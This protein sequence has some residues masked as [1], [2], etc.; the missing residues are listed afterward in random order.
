MFTIYKCKKKLKTRYYYIYLLENRTRSTEKGTKKLQIICFPHLWLV[1]TLSQFTF[2]PIVLLHIIGY[3][4][5]DVVCPSV[6]CGAQ[7][8][9]KAEME[10]CLQVTDLRITGSP[11]L[12]GLTLVGSV[13]GQS[14]RPGFEY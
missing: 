14:V 3:W 6:H 5:H 11:I 4:H 1:A 13:T 7:G 2:Q 10:S 8:R 9:C 12:A